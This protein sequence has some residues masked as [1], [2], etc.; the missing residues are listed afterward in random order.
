MCLVKINGK[1][2]SGSINLH[3]IC[4][5]VYIWR[6]M[7]TAFKKSFDKPSVNGELL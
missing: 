4:S 7:V 3:L 5:Y 6:K 2:L 1:L